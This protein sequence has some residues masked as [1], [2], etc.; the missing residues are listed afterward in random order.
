[1]DQA[2]PRAH[3]S[4]VDA[5]VDL[6]NEPPLSVDGGTT[7][8]TLLSAITTNTVTVT[9][10]AVETVA[11]RIRV[12][13]SSPFSTSD[14]PGYFAIA[15]D[16]VSPWWTATVATTSTILSTNADGTKVIRLLETTPPAGGAR[17]F[18]RLRFT[19]VP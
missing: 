4:R 9:A 12:V 14:G 10:P 2:R 19:L 11:A 1:M 6:G 7:Y 18:A 5:A 13:R 3:R 17:R 8:T 15:P 16:L